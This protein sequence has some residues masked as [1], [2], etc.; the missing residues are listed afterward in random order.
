MMSHTRRSTAGALALLFLG[1]ACALHA[2]AP[3]A[4]ITASPDTGRAPL[5]VFFD[6]SLSSADAQTFLWDFGD[7]S[8]ST[9]KSPT[10]IYNVAGTYT[11]QLT[12]ANA[13]G[14]SGSS[15]IAITVTGNSEGPVSGDMNFRWVITSSTFTLKHSQ[16]NRDTLVLN[17]VFNTVDLPARVDGLAASFSINGLFTISGVLGTEGGFANPEHNQRPSYQ[18]ILLPQEQSVSV[19]ISKA[20]L[21]AALA[22]SGATNTS[23]SRPGTLVPVTFTL[24][25]GAQ[26]Y[27][28]TE[29]FAYAS[30]A[31]SSGRGEYNLKKGTGSIA[32]GFFAIMRAS[33]LE[34]DAGS[35]HYFEFDGYLSRPLGTQLQL[36]GTGSFAFKFADADRLVIL[37]DRL[38]L[39]GA[40]LHYEQTD[41]DLGGI[42]SL[43][44]DVVSRRML[45]RTWDLLADPTQG[46]TGMPLRGAPFLSYNFALRV[47]LDQADGTTLQAV[48]ATGLTRH[49]RDD[50]FWQTG[51]RKV[52]R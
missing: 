33:A 27:S 3:G 12:V 10:H 1:A 39:S 40:K 49:T 7:G 37:F 51:R 14:E 35:G 8:A 17:S 4:A 50:A 18:F 48:T 24:T 25:I 20:E 22:A 34:N 28:I 31:G 23:V 2:A 21:K 45:I 16:T 52:S 46:G 43:S 38:R 44:I 5:P 19:V 11:A 15:Q 6:G 9:A 32:E 29:N 26:T 42:R 36:P 47:D 41:R 30:V 13:A